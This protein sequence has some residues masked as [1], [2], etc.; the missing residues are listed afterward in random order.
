MYKID[1]PKKPS[2]SLLLKILYNLK[3]YEIGHLITTD[4]LL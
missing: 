1:P 2:N 4:I 3:F